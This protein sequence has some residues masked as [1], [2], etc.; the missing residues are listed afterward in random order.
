MLTNTIKWMDIILKHVDQLWP[1]FCTVKLNPV[2][3][4]T[5]HG[6][7]NRHFTLNKW[8]PIRSKVLFEQCDVFNY[9]CIRRRWFNVVSLLL[10]TC[11]QYITYNTWQS[12]LRKAKLPR[13]FEIMWILNW[14][15]RFHSSWNMKVQHSLL[16][17][18]MQLISTYFHTVYFCIIHP[19]I[20]PPPKWW[21]K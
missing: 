10:I 21:L 19:H 16:T 7:Q 12:S 9:T 17:L 13:N 11:Q 1:L 18:Q 3:S 6:N 5:A 4:T 20:S 2:L 15:T 8:N 14:S